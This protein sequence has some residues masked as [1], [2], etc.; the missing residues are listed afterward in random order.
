MRNP[1]ARGR[2]RLVAIVQRLKSQVHAPAVG[3]VAY[4]VGNHAGREAGY[5][6]ADYIA[7]PGNFLLATFANHGAVLLHQLRGEELGLFALQLADDVAEEPEVGAF[8]AVDVADFLRR[9][10]HFVVA[11]QVVEEHETAVKV[12]ALQNEI[13]HQCAGK[14]LRGSVVLELVVQ[15]ADKGVAAQ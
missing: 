3:K 8:I 1:S 9:A 6:V 4:V 7:P 5:I 11:A 12:N 14:V 15:V 10:G 2:L 13:S